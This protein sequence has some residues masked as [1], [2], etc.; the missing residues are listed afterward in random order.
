MGDVHSLLPGLTLNRVF[1]GDLMAAAAPCFALGYV[2]ERQA[3]S[4]FLALRPD[5]TIPSAVTEQGFCFG[6]CVLGLQ[7]SPVLQFT[8]EFYDHA[9]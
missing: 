4:G 8:F 2:E 6:H 7:G 9:R 3:I 5:K 1:V